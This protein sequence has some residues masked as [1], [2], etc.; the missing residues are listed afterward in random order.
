VQRARRRRVRIAG[1]LRRHDDLRREPLGS[2]H[3]CGMPTITPRGET[4]AVL[5]GYLVGMV[6]SAWWSRVARG[7]TLGSA[8]A[9]WGCESAPHRSESLGREVGQLSWIGTQQLLA[10]GGAAEDHFGTAVALTANRVLVGAPEDDDVVRAAPPARP[11]AHR[12]PATKVAAAAP[13]RVPEPQPAERLRSART[14]DSPSAAPCSRCCSRERGEHGG[15]GAPPTSCYAAER[16]LHG[17][18]YAIFGR[19]A[20]APDRWLGRFLIRPIAWLA[21]SRNAGR[22][23]SST[24]ARG[25]RTAGA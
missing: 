9:S 16:W 11:P 3:P 15:G 22:V 1:L 6:G 12:A 13:W 23:R 17:G 14:R 24:A 25:P 2:R 21:N 5:F 10:P 8:L 7:V 19:S 18:C 20:C 4:A